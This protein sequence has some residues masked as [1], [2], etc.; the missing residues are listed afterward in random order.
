MIINSRSFW[1]FRN[2][3]AIVAAIAGFVVICLFTRHSGIGVSPDSVSYLSVASHIHDRGAWVDFHGDPLV[4]FPG[5]YPLFLAIVH[6]VTG[7]EPLR[8]APVVNGLLFAAFVYFCGWMMRDSFRSGL[9]KWALLALIVTSPCLLEVYTMLWSETL[10]LLLELLF[11]YLLRRY[12]RLGSN[13]VLIVAALIAGLAFVTRYAGIALIGTGGLLLLCQRKKLRS[14]LLFGSCASVFPLINLLHNKLSGAALI[15]HREKGIVSFGANLRDFGSVF[16]DWLHIPSSPHF[17]ASAIGLGWILL[18][19]L[20]FVSRL[21]RGHKDRD[22]KEGF[23]SM[24]Y[25]AIAFFVV[26]TLFILLSATVS[27]FQPLDSRLLSPLFIPWIWG[28]AGLLREWAA[29]RSP[30]LRKIVILS[31]IVAGAAFLLG[32]GLT[33]RLN[34]EDQKDSGVPGYTDDDWRGSPTMEALRKNSGSCPPSGLYSNAYDAIWFLGGMQAGLLPHKDDQR[35][36]SSL[37]AKD[38][39][40]VVWFND[41]LNPDLVDIAWISLHKKLYSQQRYE[42]GAIYLFTGK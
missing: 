15:G 36:R 3:D 21:A 40:C 9:A 19:V 25:I 29:S 17:L 39:L 34:W 13:S 26:Y 24:P 22:P 30:A 20:V 42:D 28:S 38:T 31:L 1:V 23:S 27:R 6:W 8:T 33:D 4:D 10:F 12:F 37:L 5:F 14:L 2:G 11:F 16:C 41:G 35:E 7:M 32:Q 18:F